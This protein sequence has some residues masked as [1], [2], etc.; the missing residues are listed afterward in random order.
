M[1]PWKRREIAAGEFKA[2]CLQLME[3]VRASGV[4]LVITK[5][6][7]PIAKLVPIDETERGS[8]IGWLAGRTRIVGDIVAP[9]P[10]SWPEADS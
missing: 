3:E 10:E 7:R 2:R 5:R 1:T 6:G 4:E 9:D 8:A